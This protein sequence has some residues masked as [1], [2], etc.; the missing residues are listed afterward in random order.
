MRD[1]SVRPV[2]EADLDDIVRLL[3]ELDAF[4]GDVATESF[5]SRTLNTREALVG[6]PPSVHAVIARSSTS[7]PIGFATY[8]FLWP[9]AGSSRSL[10]LKEL[11]VTQ[12]QRRTGVGS[13]LMRTLFDIANREDCSR[14][15]WTTET[16]NLDAV[17]FYE[18]L[19]ASPISEKVFYRYKL[20]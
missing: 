1:V 15:E 13:I 2:E 12:A 19:G 9:A 17:R 6:S 4:Y 3:N 11:Y 14:V 5:R 10:Y 18:K 20:A 16:S 7:E 8:S